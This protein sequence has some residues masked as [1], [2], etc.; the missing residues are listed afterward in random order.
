M[1]R[2]GCI[3]GSL[4]MADARLPRTHAVPFLG[5]ASASRPSSAHGA[6]SADAGAAAG[7]ARRARRVAAVNATRRAALPSHSRVA[8][9]THAFSHD[10]FAHSRAVRMGA[11]PYA[12]CRRS[13]GARGLQRWGAPAWPRF[14]SL[15]RLTLPR[16]AGGELLRHVAVHVRGA[17]RGAGPQRGGHR[18]V[19][20]LG[21]LHGRA[22]DCHPCL[23]APDARRHSAGLAPAGGARSHRGAAGS[24]QRRRAV[25]RRGCC[26]LRHLHRRGAGASRAAAPLVCC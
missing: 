19:A 7:V 17:G 10:V 1:C 26:G 15:R 16:C 23:G 22:A 18:G 3:R 24:R 6:P 25:R 4:R 8:L 14:F 2:H 12:C 9:L 21:C 5:A 11:G 13:H 20:V